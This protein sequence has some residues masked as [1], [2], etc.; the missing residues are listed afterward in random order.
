MFDRGQVCAYLYV[1]CDIWSS[2]P[3]A[4]GPYRKDKAK[5]YK[6]AKKV[7]LHDLSSF[8]IQT[9]LYEHLLGSSVYTY[10]LIP[11]AWLYFVFFRKHLHLH[12]FMPCALL[13]FMH[14]PFMP[15]MHLADCSVHA[16][17]SPAMLAALSNIINYMIFKW[18]KIIMLW[19]GK[20][21]GMGKF[22]SRKMSECILNLSCSHGNLGRS[23][24]VN[25]C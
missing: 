15:G 14:P 12:K 13:S 8:C 24:R 18:D 2:L 16:N 21:Y 11:A 7:S 9:I 3:V 23:E 25:N 22:L 20:E 5:S 1:I 4:N 17:T 19:S 10:T 6:G